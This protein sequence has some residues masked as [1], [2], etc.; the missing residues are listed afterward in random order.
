M[1]ILAID[2]GYDRMGIAILN[3]TAVKPVVLHS[4]CVVTNRSDASS[5]R[6]WTL[7][8]RLDEIIETYKPEK[9]IV[10]S[11]LFSVNQKTAIGVAEAR[12][13]IIS[14]AGRYGVPVVSLNPNEVKVAVTGYGG[15]KKQGVTDMVKRLTKTREGIKYDDE[16][17]AIAIGI[18]ALSINVL[19]K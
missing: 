7:A 11:L 16:Y 17:D 15:S 19:L 2:P 3:G 18:A 13:A 6:L 1:A 8:K 9:M 4:E 12:G 5:I 14:E 10:E